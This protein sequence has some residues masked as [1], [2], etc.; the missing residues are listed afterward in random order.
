MGV[1]LPFSSAAILHLNHRAL[2][3][4]GGFRKGRG[5]GL[6]VVK[7]A[8]VGRLGGWEMVRG[9]CCTVGI[10]VFLMAWSVCQPMCLGSVI[11]ATLHFFSLKT[12][13][14][15]DGGTCLHIQHV[16]DQEFRARP[17]TVGL[18]PGLAT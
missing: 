12:F 3:A 17:S 5:P 2:A 1:G 7:E 13:K 6:T 14:T 11:V 10:N 8:F 4:L 16:E 9:P 18:N 15:R